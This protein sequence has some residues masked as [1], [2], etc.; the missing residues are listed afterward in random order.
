MLINLKKWRED[1]ISEKLIE[2]K[3]NG[4]NYFMDQDAL[5]AVLGKK[6]LK[7]EFEYN[8]MSTLSDNL[9]LNDI[10]EN[11][12][13]E[14]P[15]NNFREYLNKMSI[16]HFTFNL[17]PWEYNLP[18]YTDLFI[19]YY[20]RTPY[21]DKVLELKSPIKLYKD[22]I[23]Q[24]PICEELLIPYKEIGR[25]SRIVIYG[26]GKIGNRCRGQFK[27]FG[28]GNVVGWVD[29]YKSDNDV[30]S[31]DKLCELEYDYILVAIKNRTT[32]EGIIDELVGIYGVPSEKI[33]S[34]FKWS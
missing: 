1:N 31:I 18:W 4:I 16:V 7:L 10:Y 34:V 12:N 14:E 22:I 21:K 27:I 23:L 26:A 5:N 30:S 9:D 3:A 13:V 11:F 29:K 15:I 25:D 17:K 28:Y 19:K 6:R 2:Y 8:F 24:K 32:V 20:N 33:L